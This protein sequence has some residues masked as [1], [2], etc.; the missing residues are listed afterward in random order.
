MNRQKVIK[1]TKITADV[2]LSVF[3]SVAI[4][5]LAVSII[6]SKSTDGVEL[7]GH[8]LRTVTTESMEE[9]ENA[10]VS[11]YDIGSI[12]QGSMVLIKTVP[13]EQEQAAKW[14]SE[15][16]VGDV[17]TFKYFYVN[18][19]TVTHRIIDISENGNGGY[20]IRLA[21]DNVSVKERGAAEQVINTSDVDSPNYVIGKVVGKSVFLGNVVEFMK[22]TLG[23]VV[24]VMIPCFIILVLEIIKLTRKCIKKKMSDAQE[25][26]ASLEAEKNELLEKLK[27][28][29]DS[30]N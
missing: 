21:G 12:P 20:I 18:Q 13:T 23:L 14:Y 25:R 9:N 30:A 7:L 8:Q 27:R 6:S 16:K 15:L 28:L 17:L 2:L 24:M 19:I 5:L 10:D 3:L 11:T 4:I 26:I 29:E 22:T 1:I